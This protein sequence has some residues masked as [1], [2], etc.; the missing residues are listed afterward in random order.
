ML[1]FM[2][3]GQTACTLSPYLFNLYAEP[4]K[5]R[6]GLGSDGGRV[7]TGGGNTNHLR[8]AGD[9]VLLE[10]SSSGLKQL[11]TK[12]KEESAKTGLT[13]FERQE[14][15]NPTA[16]ELHNFNV[17]SEDTEIVKESV[18]LGS[19]ID[20]NGGCSHGT[21]G[22][23]GHG[24]AAMEELG[25][26]T[27]CEEVSSDTKAKVVHTLVL[28]TTVYACES[29]AVKKAAGKNGFIGNMV[30]GESSADTLDYQKGDPWVP[31]QIRPEL[32][33]EAKMVKL[34]PSY[35]GH[36]MR[37]QDSGKDSNAGNSRGS[38]RRGGPNR[39]RAD[40]TREAVGPSPQDL[41]GAAGDRTLR[42]SLM[43]RVARSGS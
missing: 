11:L 27:R 19:V 13:A 8:S 30:L 22:R 40:P 26:I 32:S 20:L 18:C 1:P 37:R 7:K 24:R 17:D 34:R 35:V 15:R 5:R 10:E 4:S 43:H 12:V 6:T 25:R 29:W 31:E 42:T 39:R 36:I 33:L 28:P 16:E 38:R 9:T 41:S 21:K 3:R 14:D 2:P 23:L